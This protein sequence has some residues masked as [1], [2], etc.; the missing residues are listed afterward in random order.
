M[1]NFDLGNHIP[2]LY[3]YKS[4]F[5]HVFREKTDTIV[6]NHVKIVDGSGCSSGLGKTPT[7]GK[8]QTLSLKIPGCMTYGIFAHEFIHSY[9]LNHEQERPDRDDFITV[10]Y[11]NIIKTY[12][13]FSQFKVCSGCK[14]FDVPYDGR[15]VMQYRYNAFAI[16]HSKPT[17]ISKVCRTFINH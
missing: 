8:Q 3:N 15:S 14:T 5:A 9:G 13:A 2:S 10:D 4:S 11:N 7:E 16:D 6:E 1:G 12:H 17:M